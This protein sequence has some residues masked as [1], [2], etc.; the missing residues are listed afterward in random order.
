M[1]KLEAQDLFAEDERLEQMF[2]EKM[3]LRERIFMLKCEIEAAERRSQAHRAEIEKTDSMIFSASADV[4]VLERQ[5]EELTKDT[6][7]RLEKVLKK[8]E[9]FKCLRNVAQNQLREI[10]QKG[11][12]CLKIQSTEEGK[13]H[14]HDGQ[15]QEE[16]EQQQKRVWA[17]QG[18]IEALESILEYQT[19]KLEE[20][21]YLKQL[22]AETFPEP[23][24]PKH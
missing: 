2:H 4:R 6:R 3:A 7:K 14:F 11:K 23:E 1:N 5:V 16:T 20:V 10:I 8:E 18:E 24:F 17:L 9:K 15:T 12:D 21:R 19:K 13:L 22:M